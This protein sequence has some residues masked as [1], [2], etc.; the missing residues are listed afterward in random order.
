MI[1]EFAVK[2][3]KPLVSAGVWQTLRGIYA[4]N[5]PPVTA[6]RPGLT[7]LAVKYGT[8]KWGRHRYTPHY[9]FHL[10]H[11]KDESFTLLEIGIGGYKRKRAG[12][13]SLRMWKEYFS[14]AQILGL[15]IE[16][17][18]F[19]NEDRIRAYQGSQVD[20]TLL[21]DIVRDAKNLRVVI[22]D[23]SHRNDH[24]LKTFADL[25][26]MLPDNV[27][28]I[29]EDTETSYRENYGGSRDLAAPGTTMNLV[30]GLL[31]GL[32]YVEY[33]DP[34]YE[35]SYTERHV[36]GVH[37]YHNLVVIEKGLNDE[38]RSRGPFTPEELAAVAANHA[39]GGGV[40]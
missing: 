24:V 25:F 38:E 33:T 30:K 4:K 3:I 32:N 23:G 39:D 20:K 11:L 15:D 40:A 6:V 27:I 1:K 34:G 2:H 31:D 22:D 12:G 26:P 9:E 5:R 29:I 19:V 14:H 13:A 37:A 18:S 8:D 16:D 35:P 36:V 17:K 7:E 21:R 28:Y 10:S